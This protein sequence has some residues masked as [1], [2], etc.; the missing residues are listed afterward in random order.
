[1]ISQA[2]QV[3]MNGFLLDDDHYIKK[4]IKLILKAKYKDKTKK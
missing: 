2:H 3:Q 4:V 1:M